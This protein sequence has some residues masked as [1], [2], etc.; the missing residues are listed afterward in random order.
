MGDEG[1]ECSMSRRC[2]GDR[3]DSAQSVP[4]RYKKLALIGCD[5]PGHT[6]SNVVP[7]K[8]VVVVVVPVTGIGQTKV[9]N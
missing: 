2:A 3:C 7:P 4:N 5:V 6:I 9:T 8:V 1:D